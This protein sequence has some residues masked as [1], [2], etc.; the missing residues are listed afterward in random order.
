MLENRR[1]AQQRGR[2]QRSGAG[3]E[4][5]EVGQ[6]LVA[7]EQLP[8]RFDVGLG[9]GLV[10]GQADM[11]GVDLAQVDALGAGFFMQAGSGVAGGQGQGVE[12]AVADDLDAQGLEAGREDRGQCVGTLGDALQAGR[13]VVHG[14]HAGDVGQQHLRGADVAGGFLAA[15]VL[16]AGL[17]GQ[18]QGGLAEAVDRH[19]DQA[20]RHVALERVTGGE[21]GRVR[22]TEAQWH[23]EALGAADGHVGAELARRGQQGQGQQ[24]GGHGDQGV[25]GVEA[26]D[27]F[28]VVEHFTVAGRV[29]QQGAEEGADIAQLALVADHDLDAQRLG[30]GAQHVEGLRV[31]MHGGEEGVAALVLAQA[32]AEGHGFG[33]GG[34]FVEQGGVGDRQAGQVADQ[35]LEVQQRFQAALG[36]FWLVRGVS[37]VPGWVFQQVAQDRCRGVGV[38]VALADKVLEQLVVA[39]DGFQRREGVGFALAVCRAEHAGALDAVGDDRCGHGIQGVEAQGAEH[40]LLVSGAGADVAGDEFVG[41]AELGGHGGYPSGVVV[42]FDQ[43]VVGILVKQGAQFAGIGGDEAEEPAFAQRVF[44][45]QLGAAIELFVGLDH[46]PGQRHVHTAGGLDRLDGGY[47]AAFLI[48]LQFRQLYE[49]HIAQCVLG[50]SGDAHGDAAIGFGAQPFVIFGETQLAH[51]NSSGKQGGG[52]GGSALLGRESP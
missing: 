5:G 19:A 23:A 22:A 14:E 45:D 48:L 33:S 44:V 47:L 28:A 35:G 13:A 39:G 8:Q 38:V 18:A 46:F 2:Q 42:G 15:D 26:L 40:G 51:E 25:G 36:D 41:G 21:V 27:H 10:E 50:K 16:L 6:G 1:L 7:G 43:A 52:R 3:G 37:G 20:A 32:F 24:V 30:T 12:S 9:A 4:G 31:A 34:G 29:L 49:D 11:A 17:H